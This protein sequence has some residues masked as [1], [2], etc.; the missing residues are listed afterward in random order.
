MMAWAVD[1]FNPRTFRNLWC[2]KS[3]INQAIWNIT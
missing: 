1:F 2:K 3:V